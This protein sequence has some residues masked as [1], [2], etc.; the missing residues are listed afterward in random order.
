MSEALEGSI[1]HC[2]AYKTLLGLGENGNAKEHTSM[3]HVPWQLRGQQQS[4]RVTA[5]V[6][7]AH[8]C[9]KYTRHVEATQ[10]VFIKRNILSLHNH[11]T[12]PNCVEI[13]RQLDS[14]LT[15]ALLS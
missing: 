9:C 14:D 4:W 12:T 6:T 7:L 3:K 8:R 11:W 1:K 15:L 2:L 10:Y 13:S 5:V